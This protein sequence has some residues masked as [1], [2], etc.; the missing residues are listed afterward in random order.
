MYVSFAKPEADF[1]TK[2]TRYASQ[3]AGA[4][5]EPGL[6]IVSMLLEAG[7]NVE[8]ENSSGDTPLQ[9]SF[10]FRDH[11]LAQILF[12]AGASM[13]REDWL[14]WTSLHTVCSNER[15]VELCILHGSNVNSAAR[16]GETPLHCAA[17][18]GYA[19]TVKLL[20][21]HGGDLNAETFE[22]HTPMDK[23]KMHGH[24]GIADYL[25]SL[26]STASRVPVSESLRLGQSSDK[27]ASSLQIQ[28]QFC[29]KDQSG[30]AWGATFSNNG[31]RI[32]TFGVEG[33]IIIYETGHFARLQVLQS[34]S[35]V[36][37]FDWSSDD[38]KFV[39]SHEDRYV[40][41]WDAIV[42]IRKS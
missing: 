20:I 26:P 19:A 37:T 16:S 17:S 5:L 12:K 1:M 39:T 27:G 32:A 13:P 22:G 35:A 14:G 7:A 41:I 34:N 29:L 8:A 23:A 9:V 30:E 4:S 25:A 18:F 42:S 36:R 11:S 3:S 24:D 38:S 40:R 10:N 15:L 6:V 28:E 33:V 2:T 31:R 21:Q